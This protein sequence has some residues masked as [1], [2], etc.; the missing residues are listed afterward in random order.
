MEQQIFNK[1]DLLSMDP[2]HDVKVKEIKIEGNTLIVSYENLRKDFFRQDGTPYYA[3]DKLTIQYY[4]ESYCSALVLGKRKY[5]YLDL[6]DFLKK[7]KRYSYLSF[8]I[9]VDDWNELTLEMDIN[10]IKH[11]KHLRTKWHTLY[12]SLDAIKVIY[13]W[14]N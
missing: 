4:F 6:S 1:E 5:I 11:G 10:K 14:S 13:E 9:S 8:R 12:I 7:Y 2:M 3:F